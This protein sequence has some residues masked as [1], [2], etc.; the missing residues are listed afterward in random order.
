MANEGSWQPTYIVLDSSELIS[1]VGLSSARVA[2]LREYCRLHGST[3]VVPQLVQLEVTN[4]IKSKIAEAA[5]AASRA[6][7]ALEGS[8]AQVPP[9]LAAVGSSARVEEAKERFEERLEWL[10]A[11]DLDLPAVSHDDVVARLLARSRPF[12][13]KQA[14]DVGYRDFLLWRNVL[15]LDAPT[16]FVTTDRDFMENDELHPDLLS[17]L[18]QEGREVRLFKGLQPLSDAI[19]RPSFPPFEAAVILGRRGRERIEDFAM[20][21]ESLAKSVHTSL[22]DEGNFSMPPHFD[23]SFN[24]RK[25]V[26]DEG[27]PFDAVLLGD[28]MVAAAYNAVV[29][30]S[31]DGTPKQRRADEDTSGHIVS[32]SQ[33]G[34]ANCAIE[35]VLDT[36]G[37]DIT[38]VAVSLTALHQAGP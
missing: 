8:G 9:E 29:E 5:D 21:S 32:W 18:E 24:I 15:S 17:D 34:G 2:L 11:S 28:N 6:T 30:Y 10:G 12:G 31:L 35:Y 13:T 25:I 19:L 33:S 3:V 16:A 37:G 1:D 14:S 4:E 23:L 36:S 27:A 20:A 22:L 7:R 26:L 38:P